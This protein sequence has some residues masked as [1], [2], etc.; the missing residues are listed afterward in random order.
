MSLESFGDEDIEIDDAASNKSVPE[1]IKGSDVW[2]YMLILKKTKK[3][4]VIFV[5]L[6]IHVLGEVQQ[7]C[8][9]I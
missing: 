8:I 9:I 5:V 3:L 2:K 4:N 1:S 6:F 7:I